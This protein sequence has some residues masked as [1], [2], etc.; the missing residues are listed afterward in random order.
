MFY[1]CICRAQNLLL[2]LCLRSTA[3]VIINNYQTELIDHLNMN[4]KNVT[5]K[6][7]GQKYRECVT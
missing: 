6:S 3:L 4:V 7:F 5:D 2:K 1:Y